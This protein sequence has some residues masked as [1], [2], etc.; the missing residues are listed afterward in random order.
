MMMFWGMLAGFATYAMHVYYLPGMYDKLQLAV[1]VLTVG[2][3]AGTAVHMPILSLA[4]PAFF[5]GKT[6]LAVH[7]AN[8]PEITWTG[9]GVGNYATDFITLLVIGA[10]G[11]AWIN[12][13]EHKKTA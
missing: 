10:P 1:I 8:S 5:I 9:G 4:G 6:I 3:F 11:L 2:L 12:R 13:Q 7:A